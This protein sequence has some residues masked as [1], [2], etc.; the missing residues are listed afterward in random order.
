VLIV[1]HVYNIIFMKLI[2]YNLESTIKVG[3][4][5]ISKRTY[6]DIIY[7]N[8][9]NKYTLDNNS[10]YVTGLCHKIIN[11]IP[12]SLLVCGLGFGLIPYFF[13]EKKRVSDIDIIENN[14]NIINAINQMG[15][16]NEVNI[17]NADAKN[18]ETS[19]KYDLIIID[20]YWEDGY[21]QLEIEKNQLVSKYSNNLNVGGKIYFPL[22][23]EIF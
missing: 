18:Y 6:K 7:M 13:K 23:Q 12:S 4:V 21:N 2:D 8:V 20:I 17:I 9:D 16:L 3:N 15:Y 1:E 19:K 14:T 11:Q 22:S 10:S 5:E